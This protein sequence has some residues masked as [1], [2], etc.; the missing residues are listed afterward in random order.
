MCHGA[1][2]PAATMIPPP[3]PN[4]P[5]VASA[6]YAPSSYSASSSSSQGRMTSVPQALYPA[7]SSLPGAYQVSPLP[8]LS[9]F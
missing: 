5:S 1:S 7:T 2:G 6:V 4:P 9:R 8:A 3:A